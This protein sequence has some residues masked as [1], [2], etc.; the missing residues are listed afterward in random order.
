MAFHHDERVILADFNGRSL[1]LAQA[2]EAL[3][4][5]RRTLYYWIKDGRLRTVR[6]RMG[7]QRVLLES[8]ESSWLERN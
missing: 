6:T 2:G 7:S 1:S 3:R 4:V 8:L 5:S